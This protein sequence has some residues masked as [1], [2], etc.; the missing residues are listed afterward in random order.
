MVLKDHH[1]L[2]PTSHGT[3]PDQENTIRGTPKRPQHKF[4]RFI[5]RDKRKRQRPRQARQ[6][7]VEQEE[8]EEE[9]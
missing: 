3:R 5:V 1:S 9:E 7:E 8:V 6:A 2:C 4:S